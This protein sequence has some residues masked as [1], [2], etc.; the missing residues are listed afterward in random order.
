KINQSIGKYTDTVL[1]S[2]LNE[3]VEVVKKTAIRGDIVLLSPAC[4]SF[5]QF[6]GYAERGRKFVELLN[7]IK[8]VEAETPPEGC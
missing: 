1:V 7:A 5:D 4:S 2:N 8:R 6:S 3:A